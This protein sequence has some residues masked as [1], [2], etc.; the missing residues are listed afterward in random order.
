MLETVSKAMSFARHTAPDEH[1]GLADKH[2]IATE[3]PDL[4]LAHEWPIDSSEAIRLAIA[5]ED[6]ARRFDKRITN[7]EGATVATSTG[8]RAYGNTHGFLAAFPRTSHTISCVVIGETDGDMQR[9][10]YY[11]SARNADELEDIESIGREAAERTV[12]RLG[13]RKMQTTRAPVIF[14]P[15]LARGFIGHAVSALAGGAQYRRA[16]FLLG[17]AGEQVFPSFVQIEERPHIPGAI[18]SAPFDAEGVATQDRDLVR[19]GVLQGYILGSYSARRLGLESTGNAGGAHNLLVP[20]SAGDQQA[21]VRSMGTGLLVHELIGQ[22]V[23]GVT[24]DYSRGAVGFWVEGGE[25]A[26]PVHEITI[27][28][29]LRDLYT[30]ISAVGNDQDLR[31]GIRCGSIL[32]EEMAIAGA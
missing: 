18:A 8:R 21:L 7:S 31:G 32:V 14:R 19:D 23:N 28:G 9:D 17:A 13:A 25:I 12:S 22:G 30:R 29:N 10:Y 20:G 27:A 4:D 1:A 5:C 2:R 3:V 6:A 24:G 15:E 11:S 26:Y 16:S